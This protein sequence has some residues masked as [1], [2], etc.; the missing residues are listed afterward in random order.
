MAESP[1]RSTKGCLFLCSLFIHYAVFSPGQ[2]SC[3]TRKA[4]TRAY[5]Q[6]LV[7]HSFRTTLISSLKGV[8]VV[9][10]Y[11]KRAETTDGQG[12]CWSRSVGRTGWP[13]I[14]QMGEKVSGM[15]RVMKFGWNP[16]LIRRCS[17][18]NQLHTPR[19]F[20]QCEPVPRWHVWVSIV[21]ARTWIYRNFIRINIGF[22]E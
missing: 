16:V 12:G 17:S 14:K 20:N 11:Q 21:W 6:N 1:G 13:S 5:T 2:M 7:S 18:N 15:D 4:N 22:M 10:V 9:A 3:G 19:W 8:K